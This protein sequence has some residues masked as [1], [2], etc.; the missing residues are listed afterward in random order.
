MYIYI[1]IIIY[2]LIKEA[3]AFFAFFAFLYFAKKLIY[4]DLY[5]VKPGRV[6]PD[7]FFLFKVIRV[8]SRCE[9]VRAVFFFLRL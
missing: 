7:I 9:A 4:N 2:I 3:I 8:W 5:C 1:Y 6:A